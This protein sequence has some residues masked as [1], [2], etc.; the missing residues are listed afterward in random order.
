[1]EKYTQQIDTLLDMSQ[2]DFSSKENARYQLRVLSQDIDGLIEE[3]TKAITLTQSA[4]NNSTTQR[5]LHGDAIVGYRNHLQ[6][7]IKIKE[8]VAAALAAI[9]P[10]S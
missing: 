5:E 10:M 1:M 8:D 4:L 3:Y 7:L 2:G 9:L 6:S